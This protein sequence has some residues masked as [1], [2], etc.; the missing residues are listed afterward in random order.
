MRRT[1]LALAQTVL[2]APLVQSQQWPDHRWDNWYLDVAYQLNFSGGTPQALPS[3]FLG[4]SYQ[5]SA[6]SDPLNGDL[7]LRCDGQHVINSLGDTMP[8]GHNIAPLGTAIQSL[9]V[10]VSAHVHLL[11][12]LTATSNGGELR[13]TEVDMSLSSG[14]GDVTANKGVLMATNVQG[15]T[16]F[17]GFSADTTWLLA[18]LPGTSEIL[19]FRIVA[20]STPFP[21]T[22]HY[23]QTAYPWMPNWSWGKTDRNAT[24]VT[25]RS[26]ETSIRLFRCN[27]SSGT[28]DDPV[29][30]LFTQEIQSFEFSPNGEL[31]YVQLNNPWFGDPA[32]VQLE[33]APYDSATIAL[34]V[35]TIAVDTGGTISYGSHMQ[36]SPAGTILSHSRLP[37][38]NPDS[39]FA[40]VI[41]QPNLAGSSCGFAK[42]AVYVGVPPFPGYG[43]QMMPSLWWPALPPDVAISEGAAATLFN[44]YPNPTTGVI[45]VSVDGPARP[46]A[47]RIHD[48]AGRE[49]LMKGGF[50]DQRGT[51]DISTLTS[52]MYVLSAYSDGLRLWSE[53]LVR[54]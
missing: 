47:W 54:Q 52:G 13:Y 53:R 31:L 21:Y 38:T 48:A 17:S 44:T 50:A 16:A 15:V 6:L 23:S 49:V 5:H 27:R 32:L 45:T 41:A 7:L 12:T 29:D 51:L 33:L 42:D 24:F 25:F 2:L 20:G 22:A 11:V 35:D 30:V 26:S 8:N 43:V 36:L 4:G 1:F 40:S 19:G 46:D 18:S 34:S 9:I 28:L 14:F 39:A 3:G 37:S 10:T